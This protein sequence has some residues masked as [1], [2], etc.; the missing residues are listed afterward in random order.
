MKSNLVVAALGAAVAMGPADSAYSR[1]EAPARSEANVREVARIQSQLDSAFVALG[2]ADLNRYDAAQRARRSALVAT[3]RG[4]RDRGVFP[5]NYDFAAPTPYF[6]DRKTGTLCAVA[7]L[8][9]STGRRDMV[10]RIAAANNNVWVPDLAVDSAVG[11]WLNREGITLAEAALIQEPYMI[12]PQPSSKEARDNKA[13]TIATFASFG[14]ALFSLSGDP[15]K[16]ST[17][18]AVGALVGAVG[19]AV[20]RAGG[21]AP[22][23]PAFRRLSVVA[24]ATSIGIAALRHFQHRGEVRQAQLMKTIDIQPTADVSGRSAGLTVAL[25]F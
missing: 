2:S 17:R 1:A 14:T 9:E 22:P 24:G 3:L 15:A 20:G 4:Y 6:I 23:D 11:A 5:H 16:S 7:F 25:R 19:V 13:A 8:M 10:D 21:V 18:Y 12:V